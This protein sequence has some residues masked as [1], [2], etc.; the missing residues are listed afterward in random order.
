MSKRFSIHGSKIEIGHLEGQAHDT[1]V[2]H[3]LLQV[4]NIGPEMAIQRKVSELQAQFLHPCHVEA[5]MPLLFSQ[6]VSNP[7]AKRFGSFRKGKESLR[8][9]FDSQKLVASKPMQAYSS[10]IGISMFLKR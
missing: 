9:D 10:F 6:G 2:L 5:D 3:R 7:F 1:N 8:H 4:G